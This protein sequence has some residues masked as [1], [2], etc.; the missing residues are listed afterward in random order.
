MGCTV[1]PSHSVPSFMNRFCRTASGPSQAL[2][3]GLYGFPSASR[4]SMSGSI[5]AS[6]AGMSPRPKA[7]YTSRASGTL[8]TIVSLPYAGPYAAPSIS[9]NRR[10]PYGGTGAEK[11]KAAYVR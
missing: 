5:I 1:K 4:H 10:I 9:A 6:T 11:R 2:P 3:S 7:S 8:L